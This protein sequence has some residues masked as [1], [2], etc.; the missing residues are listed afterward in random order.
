[1]DRDAGALKRQ[2]AALGEMFP[3]V[4]VH[5]LAGDYTRPLDLPPL[6]GIVM[7]NTLHFLPRKEPAL[8]LV[9]GWLKPGGRLIIVEYNVD[10]GNPWVPHPFSFTTWESLAARSGFRDTQLLATQPSRFL[11]EI[12]S[13]VSL[14]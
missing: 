11:G 10:R 8:A 7:A 2:A 6:D 3:Q 14:V 5:Y 4:R 13:A 12:Y 1:V 9:R